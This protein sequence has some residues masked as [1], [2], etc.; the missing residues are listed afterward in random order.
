MPR[1]KKVKFTEADKIWMEQNTDYALSKETGKYIIYHCDSEKIVGSYYPKREELIFAGNSEGNPLY[2][3]VKQKPNNT[4]AKKL[5][6]YEQLIVDAT[7][8]PVADIAEIEDYMR[9]AI[10]HSTLSWQTKQQLNVAAIQ[11]WK[12]IQWMRSPEGVAYMNEA[13]AEFYKKEDGGSLDYFNEKLEVIKGDGIYDEALYAI[14]DKA[15]KVVYVQGEYSYMYYN[16]LARGFSHQETKEILADAKTDSAFKFAEYMKDGGSVSEK[17]DYWYAVH[18]K[19]MKPWDEHEQHKIENATWAQAVKEVKAIANEKKTEVRLS[20]SKGYNN[21]GYYFQF[22][23]RMEKGGSIWLSVD[24]GKPVTFDEFVQINT[25]PDVHAPTQDEFENVKFLKVGETATIGNVKIE[26]VA[27]TDKQVDS[28][29]LKFKDET[30]FNKAKKHFAEKS[31][32][33][34]FDVNDEF[35]SFEFQVQG[36]D[37]ADSLEHYIMQELE[38]DTDL[39]GFYFEGNSSDTEFE[40]GGSVEDSE[41]KIPKYENKLF[42]LGKV[43]DHASIK[44][45]T[46]E[47]IQDIISKNKGGN[48]NSDYENK[49]LEN[50]LV[51]DHAKISR[52]TAE[53]IQELI[54]K[55]K[56]VDLFFGHLGNGVSVS[57]RNREEN[58]DYKKVAHISE[59]GEIQ[60]YDKNLPEYAIKQIEAAAKPNKMRVDYSHS[61]PEHINVS[62]IQKALNGSEFWMNPESEDAK[63]IDEAVKW[64]YV[65]RPSHTQAYWTDKGSKLF[66]QGGSVNNTAEILIISSKNPL[67]T[68][69]QKKTGTS[70]WDDLYSS[71]SVHLTKAGD[72]L[73]AVFTANYF[74][75]VDKHVINDDLSYLMQYHGI[76]NF[77]KAGK[78]YI[79]NRPWIKKEQGGSI[80]SNMLET[81]KNLVWAFSNAKDLSFVQKKGIEYAR[82]GIENPASDR[83][84]EDIENLLWNFEGKQNWNDV[85]KSALKQARELIDSFVVNLDLR[86]N[87]AGKNRNAAARWIMDVGKDSAKYKVAALL[88]AGTKNPDEV[89]GIGED[90]YANILRSIAKVAESEHEMAFRTNNYSIAEAEKWAKE[91]AEKNF[92]LNNKMEQGGE[93]KTTEGGALGEYMGGIMVKGGFRLLGKNGVK[94]MSDYSKKYPKNIYIVTDDNYSNIGNFYLRNGKFARAET[95]GN[96]EYDFANNVVSFRGKDDVIYKFKR[97]NKQD[98]YKDGGTV[99]LTPNQQMAA[100]IL[101]QLGGQKRLKLFTGAYDI[102][103]IDNGVRFK[104]KNVDR[105]APNYVKIVLTPMDLYDMEIGRIGTKTDMQYGTKEDTYKIVHK[106]QGVYDDMLMDLFE[107]GTGMYLHFEKGG[108]VSDGKIKLVVVDNH[109]LATLRPNATEVY[110]IAASVIRGSTRTSPLSSME[111]L[112]IGSNTNIR[113]ASAKDFD[114][115]RVSFDGYNNE[116]V[117]EFDKSETFAKGGNIQQK[118]PDKRWIVSQLRNNLQSRVDYPVLGAFIVGSEAKGT[119]NKNS[120]LDI[121]VIIPSSDKISALKRTENYHAKFRSDFDKP[122]WNG[123]VVDFQFFYE[124]DSELAGYSK[125]TLKM[126]DGGEVFAKGGTTDLTPIQK[127]RV[128]AYKKSLNTNSKFYEQDVADFIRNVKNE[129]PAKSATMLGNQKWLNSEESERYVNHEVGKLDRAGMF[130]INRMKPKNALD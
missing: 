92:V 107:K 43:I 96:P 119:A 2:D 8:C 61:K 12:D 79:V 49:I 65:R 60:Y 80:K 55:T 68:Q 48:E 82:A 15:S 26:R 31:D 74:M 115:F 123:R 38:G 99:E 100:T 42:E 58:Y 22:M 32:F 50:G 129:T 33:N 34:P 101:H 62:A 105:G 37:D 125:I 27:E 28:L 18:S 97:I 45:K 116:D 11:A 85:Q 98:Y 117:Y 72:K 53:K 86:T 57:D 88:L 104:I 84:K 75:Q 124:G 77:T 114:D 70:S 24:K 76:T 41:Y 1:N 121:A 17:K 25:A 21:Q 23:D 46:A 7:N 81:L 118:Y 5:S 3:L 83:V 51:I 64:G 90:R 67:A 29:S 120:D 71:H 128:A 20:K 36:Q 63:I 106:Y 69:L 16:I 6:Y 113:L 47:K 126:E 13:T 78:P 52:E 91:S 14:R 40:S 35:R 4:P 130:N 44:F 56:S 122:K 94:T 95:W 111:P 87:P 93:I 103:A 110:P 73:F 102:Y 66:K 9:H 112:P 127:E 10:F 108:E 109:T 39:Q 89:L 19:D 54:S 59:E 30:N